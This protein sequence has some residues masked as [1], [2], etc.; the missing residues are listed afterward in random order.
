MPENSTNTMISPNKC[1]S[2][3]SVVTSKS[4]GSVPVQAPKLV[5]ETESPLPINGGSG[6]NVCFFPKGFKPGK[7]DVIIGRG[8]KCHSHFGNKRLKKIISLRLDEY[9]RAIL[10]SEKSQILRAIVSQTRNNHPYNGGFVKQDPQT[11]RWFDVGDNLARE[12]ISKAFRDALNRRH[13]SNVHNMDNEYNLSMPFRP[14]IFQ[15]NNISRKLENN[16]MNCFSHY[17]PA[18]V[19]DDSESSE[20]S[21]N[22]SPFQM[23]SHYN[24]NGFFEDQQEEPSMTLAALEKVENINNKMMNFDLSSPLDEGYFTD[25]FE[26]IDFEGINTVAP[27]SCLEFG[28]IE[29]DIES[30]DDIE[31]LEEIDTQGLDYC[32]DLTATNLHGDVFSSNFSPFVTQKAMMVKTKKIIQ[33]APS[34]PYA[35]NQEGIKHYFRNVAISNKRST[36]S[37]R[38]NIYTSRQA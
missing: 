38:L 18:V 4:D 33:T 2:S 17:S 25:D 1:K 5:T 37:N 26:E 31:G 32:D 35:T 10:Q 6:I 27:N 16:Q 20:G 9:S 30:T 14:T 11:S 7:S 8:K 22:E 24:P 28:E 34:L 15:I 23:Q 19:S 13:S 36:A 3:P 21:Y 12:K 29:E